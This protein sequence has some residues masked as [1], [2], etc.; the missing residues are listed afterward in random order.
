[1]TGVA[2]RPDG[3]TQAPNSHTGYPQ[4]LGGG[5]T[6]ASK[7]PR[8]CHRVGSFHVTGMNAA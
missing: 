8:P 5:N 6:R 3:P 4:E 7:R 1:M 2:S